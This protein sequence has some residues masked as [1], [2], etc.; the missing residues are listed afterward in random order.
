MTI[1]TEQAASVL[2]RAISE[3]LSRRMSDPRIVGVVSITHVDVAPDFKSAMVYVSVLPE[4][5]EKRTLAGL[6]HAAGHIYSKVCDAVRMRIVPRLMFRLDA[7]MKKQAK[8]FDAIREGMPDD[9][10]PTPSDDTASPDHE[11]P[12]T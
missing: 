6:Q 8:V 9:P 2:K 12:S 5:Y 11:E 10:E 7:T 3:V 4:K 1:K